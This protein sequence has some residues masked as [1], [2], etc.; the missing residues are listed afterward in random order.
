MVA[1]SRFT[2]KK[3]ST[4]AKLDELVGDSKLRP[5]LGMSSIG[6]SCE[7]YLWY[8]FR[9]CYE[10]KINARLKRLFNRGHRE[11]PAI[12]HELR[13]IG[14][15]HYDDQ[16][17]VKMAFGH[18]MGHCDGKVLGVI[19]A[20]KTP[21]LSEFKTMNDKKFKQLVKANS[22]KSHH[23]VYY[24][25][26][27]IYMD[28]MKLTRAFFVTVNKNDDSN[29]V[30]R[31]KLDVEYAKELEKKAERIVLAEIPPERPFSPTWF[32]CKW[33]DACS[34]CHKGVAIKETCRTCFYSEIHTEGVWKCSEHKI[35]LSTDQQRT[36]CDVYRQIDLD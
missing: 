15:I 25:Q 10:K 6:H 2:G 28:K 4:A 21:H 9:W 35:V 19:E 17:E 8:T 27:Q 32:E 7:R 18:S 1:F 3:N 20:P 11:E 33:C 5:Y 22:I 23:P 29:Y 24:G 31:I 14:I 13:Q 12:V 34:M 30:E 36:P 16:A 26:M